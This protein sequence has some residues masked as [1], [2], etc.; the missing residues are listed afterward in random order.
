MKMQPHTVFPINRYS[1]SGVLVCLYLH[2]SMCVTFRS[3][4]SQTS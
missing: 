3:S 4:G 2:F 1:N